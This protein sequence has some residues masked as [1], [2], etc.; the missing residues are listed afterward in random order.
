MI[1]T[2]IS[3]D[4]KKLS[5]SCLKEKGKKMRRIGRLRNIDFADILED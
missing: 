1:I 2:I 4:Q 5:R 3:Q